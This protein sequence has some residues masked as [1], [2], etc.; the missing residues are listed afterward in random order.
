[1]TT[2]KKVTSTGQT[3]DEAADQLAKRPTRDSVA[4]ALDVIGDRWIFLILREAFFG[5]RRYDDLRKN[6]GASPNILAD[7]LR[8]L[9]EHGIL[10][11]VQYSDHRNR[12]EYRLTD[13]GLDLYPMIVL[14]LAWGDKWESGK[15][16]P[17]L[18]LVHTP[19]G[20][21]L[22]PKLI[23]EACGEG[24]VAQDVRWKPL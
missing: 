16:G 21:V 15:K 5:V 11:K 9:V 17:P 20:H 3:A 10:T 6:L 18:A 19:C 4:A 22:S 8:R 23:C 14:L 2:K 24:V 13:K 12:F 7:R 1:M